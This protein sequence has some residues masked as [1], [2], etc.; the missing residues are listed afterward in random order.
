MEQRTIRLNF[1]LS[2]VYGPRTWR[3]P[4]VAVMLLA[5]VGE[6]N[7]ESVTLS[8][9][10][11][12]PS[13]VYTNM[14]TTGNTFLARD[15]LAGPAESRVGIG[16]T[17]PG[18]KLAVSGNMTVGSAYDTFVA[19]ASGLIV[20]GWM[21]VGMSTPTAGLDVRGNMNIASSAGGAK[22]YIHINAAGCDLLPTEKSSN[23]TPLCPATRYATF[24]P[25]IF[26][27]GTSF[28]NYPA[29][30]LIA[31]DGSTRLYKALGQWGLPPNA[32][33]SAMTMGAADSVRY[34]CCDK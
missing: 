6:L 27:E 9:Y 8:T 33:Q 24:T 7:S 5:A 34:V 25:G 2:F 30:F 20:S 19:P 11:P 10:Y 21:G 15:P 26:I 18:A 14:I 32:I 22:G 16:T 3:A 28:Q 17:A 1:D 13:G 29:P 12:A 31:P 23:F 4:I